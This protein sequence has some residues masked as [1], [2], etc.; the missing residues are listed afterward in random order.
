MEVVVADTLGGRTRRHYSLFRIGW[1]AL[2]RFDATR[3]ARALLNAFK[4]P[5]DT[6]VDNL[7]VPP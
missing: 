7:R 3:T 2:K 4:H 6:F 1:E 5:P